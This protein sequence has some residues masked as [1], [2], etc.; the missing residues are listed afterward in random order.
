M[1][2][3][4]ALRI[5]SEGFL[6]LL[7]STDSRHGQLCRVHVLPPFRLCPNPVGYQNKDVSKGTSFQIPT[8]EIVGSE[9]SNITEF[10]PVDEDGNPLSGE[11][12]VQF[13]TD[14]GKLI[15]DKQ[16]S[17]WLGEDIDTGYPDGWYDGNQDEPKS[18]PLDLGEGFVVN[19]S[20]ASGK[21][22]YSG[23]IDTGALAIPI[24]KGTAFVGN[25][26]PTAVNMSTLKPVT[27]DDEP[28]SGE[29]TIQFYNDKGKLIEDKQYSW[30]LGEDIDT[31]YE[32]GWYDG[33]QDETKEYPFVAGEGFVIN[34]SYTG[35]YLKFPAIGSK[36]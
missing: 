10:K 24:R 25:V 13:Y 34:T 2:R 22:V 33:N 11:I 7:F 31:G 5:T 30:W 19:T 17:W 15:E 1:P 23:Q 8:F 4:D 27:I 3:K 6:F 18:C 14:K 21:L 20:Y 9:G 28:V 35:A 32:D 29:I 12:T 16:Y 26:R 36:E